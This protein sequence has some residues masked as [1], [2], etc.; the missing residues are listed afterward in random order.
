[1][2]GLIIIIKDGFQKTDW[3]LGP[4]LIGILLKAGIYDLISL[5]HQSGEFWQLT[6]VGASQFFLNFFIFLFIVVGLTGLLIW[7]K[8]II[9]EY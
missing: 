5:K 7:M 8:N 3:I 4:F 1:M 9:K 6:Q 2:I